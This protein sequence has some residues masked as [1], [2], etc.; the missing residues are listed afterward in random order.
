MCVC[1]RV[2]VCACVCV[3]AGVQVAATLLSE[4]LTR[5]AYVEGGQHYAHTSLVSTGVLLAFT[6]TQCALNDSWSDL[7]FK[8]A[9]GEHN[10]SESSVSMSW[11]GSVYFLIAWSVYCIDVVYIVHIGICTRH[12]ALPFLR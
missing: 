6:C 5:D 7:S 4:R 11:S 9:H 3:C 8:A 1:I 10:E 2:C 12:K